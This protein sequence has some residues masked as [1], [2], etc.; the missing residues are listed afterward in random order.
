[1]SFIDIGP[2][3]WIFIA[4]NGVILPFW[5]GLALLAL[6]ALRQQGLTGTTQAIWVLIILAVLVLGELAFL[7]MRPSAVPPSV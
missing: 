4:I 5:L 1:M 3:E 2:G 7:I 6:F